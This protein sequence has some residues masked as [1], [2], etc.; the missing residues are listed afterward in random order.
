MPAL[1]ATLL[2]KLMDDLGGESAVMVEL[3]ETFLGEGPR[4][5]AA[6]R[7]SLDKADRRT[8]NRSAHSLKSTA[9]T[10]GAMRLSQLCRSLE[11][12]TENGIPPGTG[13]RVSEVEAEWAAVQRELAAW[14]APG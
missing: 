12:E 6:M 1:D 3:V 2:S 10:F 5:V 11:A 14:K 9:A 13:A 7:E 8:L 4:I